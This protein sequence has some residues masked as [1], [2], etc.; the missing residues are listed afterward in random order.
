MRQVLDSE[1]TPKTEGGTRIEFNDNESG[2][3]DEASGLIEKV[4]YVKIG[5]FGMNGGSQAYESSTAQYSF[6]GNM[7]SM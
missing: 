3:S 5:E 1:N 4:Q 7:T 6:G 2:K